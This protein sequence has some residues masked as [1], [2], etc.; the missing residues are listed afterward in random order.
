MWRLRSKS[1]SVTWHDARLRGLPQGIDRG[2]WTIPLV[3]DGRRVRLTGELIRVHRPRAWEW[4]ALGVPFLLVTALLL[5]RRRLPELRLGAVA[6]G[7]AAT[8]CMLA[9]DAGF[10]FDSYASEGK[11]LEF[12]NVLVFALVGC[13]VFFKLLG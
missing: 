7:L 10:A 13:A 9:A 3:L 4:F 1:P 12:G 6:F 5:V 11:W 8:A 2:R